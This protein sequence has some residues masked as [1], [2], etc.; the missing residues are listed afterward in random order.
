VI[1]DDDDNKFLEGIA[2][3]FNIAISKLQTCLDE[4]EIKIEQLRNSLQNFNWN[5]MQEEYEGA[6]EEIKS[7][8]FIACTL[9][10]Q[11]MMEDEKLVVDKIIE[12][13]E[14]NNINENSQFT[15]EDRACATYRTTYMSTTVFMVTGLF[16]VL[17]EAIFFSGKVTSK[18]DFLASHKIVPKQERLEQNVGKGD[19]LKIVSYKNDLRHFTIVLKFYKMLIARGMRVVTK[20][21]Y[22]PRAVIADDD[23]KIEEIA[24]AFNTD[25]STFQ[26]CLDEGEIKIDELIIGLQN[27]TLLFFDEKD[28]NEES[29]QFRVKLKKLDTCILKK[30]QLEI[31]YRKLVIDKIIEEV[32]KNINEKGLAQFS[33]EIFRN[34]KECLNSCKILSPIFP[35]NENSQ[36]TEEDRAFGVFPCII[37]QLKNEKQPTLDETIITLFI[38]RTRLNSYLS[39]SYRSQVYNL[40]QTSTTDGI[41][42]TDRKQFVF[43]SYDEH[44]ANSVGC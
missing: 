31:I 19:I 24:K 33:E 39:K 13:I 37:I 34:I 26:E 9:E 40:A 2:K 27:W 29:R 20:Q 28:L 42:G 10:K 4:E 23:K 43:E 11:R 44:V 1:A 14:K 6:K 41:S 17:S 16:S 38:N 30:K 3:E 21:Y 15:R 5:G 7:C 36:L 8:G 22:R 25:V 18:H 12:N 32:K 35:V